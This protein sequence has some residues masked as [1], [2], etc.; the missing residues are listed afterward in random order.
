MLALTIE[1]FMIELKDGAVQNVGPA[2]KS[3]DAKLF[4]VAAVEARAFGDKRVKF[5]FSDAEGNEVQI[6][7]FPDDAKQIVDDIRALE[8]ES[9]IFD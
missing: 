5:V 4:D 8:A 1:D 6:A 7:L 3:A 2:T 9:E